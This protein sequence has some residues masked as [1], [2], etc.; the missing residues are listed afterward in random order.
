MGLHN[1][2]YMDASSFEKRFLL[3]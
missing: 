2:D 1:A 3:D